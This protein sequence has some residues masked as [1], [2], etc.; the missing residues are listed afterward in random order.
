[1][2]HPLLDALDNLEESS[3]QLSETIIAGQGASASPLPA[4]ANRKSYL[5]TAQ[6]QRS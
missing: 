6:Q 4:A 1:M 3:L 2:K 5:V